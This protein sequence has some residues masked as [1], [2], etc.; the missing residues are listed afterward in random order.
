MTFQQPL[1]IPALHQVYVALDLETTGLSPD[2]DEIIEVGAVKF[3]GPQALDTYA[4]LVNPYRPVPAFITR[5]TGITQP[6][7]D[8]APPFAVA[9]GELASFIGDASLVGHNV[10]F[11]LAFLA[12]R[13]LQFIAPHY[14]TREIASVLFPGG[15]YSLEALAASLG[16]AHARPH[17][18]LEDADA[19]RSVFLALLARL[20]ELD[21]SLLSEWH[22]LAQVAGW[23]LRHLLRVLEGDRRRQG[24]GGFRPV[25]G[26]V[27][28]QALER[29]L[30]RVR[31]LAQKG[32][33]E[34]LA[35]EPLAA[36]L[37]PGGALARVLPGYEYRA[38]QEQMLR[39]VVRAL[40]QGEHLL[41]E[42]GTGIGKTLA[43]LLP[44]VLFAL[45]RRTRVVIATNTINLQG[46]LMEKDIP[47]ALKALAGEEG[48][49]DLRVAQLKGRS[50]YLCLRRWAH[51][52][53]SEPLALE[54]AGLL[55]KLLVWLQTTST[56]DRGELN[57]VPREA[58]A[59]ERLSAQGA[60]GCPFSEGACFLRLA[61][62]RADGAHI[63]VV[64]HALLLTDLA[65][66]GSLLPD[67]DYLVVDEAHHLEEE[68]TR[69][70]GFRLGE[71]QVL[72]HLDAL[73]GPRGLAS[74][75][76]GAYRTSNAGA[77]RRQATEK[78]AAA[79]L[80]GVVRARER[81]GQLLAGAA[82]FLQ[83]HA[84]SGS[85]RG[86]QLRVTPSSRAQP[87]WA[88]LEVAWE[89]ADLALAEVGRSLG[90]LSISLEGLE[91]NRLLNY[92]GIRLEAAG[93]LETNGAVRKGLKEFLSAPQPQSVYWMEQAGRESLVLWAAPLSVAQ[94]LKE[95]LF[96]KKRSVLLTGATLST[97]GNYAYLRQQLGLEG[98]GEL[99]LGSP[100]NYKEAALV[101]IPEDMPEPTNASYPQ[102]VAQVL[103][104]VSRAAKG[105]TL[106]LFTSHGALRAACATLRGALEAD[107]IKVLGQGV[108]GRPRQLVEEFTENPKA[109]LLGTA[110]FWEGVDITGGA[111]KVLVL[112]RLPFNVPTEPVFAARAELFEDPFNEY[113]IPQAVLRF[114]QGFGRLI[115]NRRDRGVIIALDRRI[116]SRAYGKAFLQA[117]PS[118]TVRRVTLRELP[119]VVRGWLNA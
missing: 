10:S 105:R 45:R 101:C 97:Q 46:Q 112:A 8:G 70:F 94:I 113:A 118:C 2:Q 29:R 33:G 54:E 30:G 77:S 119:Q 35:E 106:A 72:E 51:L 102:A 93:Q 44:A 56:G 23:P 36:L 53:A 104:E 116:T 108:D 92:D 27:D 37:Q 41:V 85:E 4:S 6:Q 16:V 65:L 13:G 63:L 38:E 74:E 49:E 82:G 22:R 1:E 20:M 75:A 62:E 66:G 52:R 73:A 114:R 60:K 99:S 15:R 19:T 43:Y 100:F 7:V 69:Q 115:R 24:Q 48:L 86:A 78:A 76:V 28:L 96:Q 98:G 31:P 3:R 12:R 110:S 68:A 25:P 79:L 103:A 58:S 39:A 87:G 61:R 80:E 50:N 111:L 14:D 59:W 57:L 67:H 42:A 88:A 40:N 9:A 11:D 64:N 34:P 83:N 91:G 95:R 26:G 90:Q 55:S 17:R 32:E 107:G 5:L 84:E 47:T 18:A 71:A 89:N 81:V 21:A 117:V 109:L